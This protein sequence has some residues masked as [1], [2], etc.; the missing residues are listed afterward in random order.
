MQ[1]CDLNIIRSISCNRQQFLTMRARSGPF[2]SKFLVDFRFLALQLK[3]FRH[4]TT[5]S[6]MR[7]KPSELMV[8][9]PM[10][11]MLCCRCCITTCSTILVHNLFACTRIIAAGKIPLKNVTRYQRFRF[12]SSEPGKVRASQSTSLEDKCVT[13]LKAT[14]D[15]NTV[16]T[17]LPPV[18]KR[19][20][21]S[22]TRADYLFKQVRPHCQEKNRDVTCPDPRTVPEE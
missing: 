22:R 14:A 13:I 2:I 10:A 16:S 3:P 15:I 6:S 11:R 4:N 21:M 20:G 19:A 5:T 7:T 12:L 9:S 1:S 18:L 17:T 8:V